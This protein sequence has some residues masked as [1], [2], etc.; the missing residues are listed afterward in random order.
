M[1]KKKGLTKKFLPKYIGPFQIVKKVAE[2]TYRVEELPSRRKK[3]VVR[4][5]NAHVVQLKPFRARSD[6]WHVSEID[7]PTGSE[8][9]SENR[10]EAEVTQL[11]VVPVMEE[12]PAQQLLVSEFPNRPP[13]RTRSG[14]ISRLP[15]IFEDFDLN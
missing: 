5:F 8:N 4:R 6:E 9:D 2:T 15:T 13:V 11:A 10:S 1:L 7:E 14:R 12:I 3:K